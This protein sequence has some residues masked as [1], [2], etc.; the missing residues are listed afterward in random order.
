MNHAALR[1]IKVEGLG[2][3]TDFL[4]TLTDRTKSRALL[5]PESYGLAPKEPIEEGVSRSWD[6]LRKAYA[7]WTEAR[8]E[9]PGT[10][11]VRYWIT[12]LLQELGHTDLQP[13]PALTIGEKTYPI[14]F[15]GTVPVHVTAGEDLDRITLHGS[16]R[17]SPH[18]L[19]QEFLNRSGEHTWGLVLNGERLRLLRDNAQVTRPAFVEFDLEEMFDQ[20]DSAGFRVLWLLT[21]RSRFEGGEGAII[22][23]WNK[24]A[25]AQGTRANDALRDGV[26]RAIATL[27]SGFLRR[28]RDLCAQL[29]TGERQAQDLYRLSL[30][31][32]YQ[33]IFLFVVED[34]DLLH[35]Q[36]TDPVAK[37]RYA[38]YSTRRLR[39]IAEASEG[40]ATHGDAWEGLKVLLRGMY[41]GLPFLGLPAF[42]GHLF[43]QYPLLACGLAN[44]DLYAA[45]RAL[46]LIEDGG[47]LKSVN[48]TDLDAEELG[49]IY[50][51]LLE[52]HPEINTA[53]GT[54]TLSSAAGN[55]R[56][57]TG[58]YYTPT[59][60]I[61][62]LLES[63]LDPVIEDAL[64]K[65]DP[66]AALKALNVV[67]PAC[68]SGHFLLA[69]AR[70]IGLAL[71]RAEHDVTQPSPEQL[72][73]ATREVIAH[74]IYGV[75]L[76]PM[77]IEL[78]KV[79]LWL[80]SAVPGKPLAF[81]DHRLR[82]GNSLLGT[83]PDLMRREDEIP[84]KLVRRVLKPAV[85]AVT[86]HL[87]DE[88]FAELEGDDKTT[89]R[90]LKNRNKQER[91]DLIER[92]HG[93]QGLFD[94]QRDLSGLQRMVEALDRIEPDS[95]EHVQAQESTWSAIQ[96]HAEHRR[97]KT[98]ADA[99]CAAFVTPKTPGAPA[100]TT[101]TLQD[102]DRNPDSLPNVT[103]LVGELAEQYRFFHWHVEFPDV[104]AQGGFDCVLGNP[105]WERIKLQ[106]KEWFAARVPEIAAAPNA[107]ARTRLIAG[108]KTEQ[109]AIYA[110]FVRDLRQAEGESHFI[111]ASGRYP[112]T[113]RG[114]VNTYAIF[115]ELCRQSLNPQGRMG[116]IV[117]TGIATDDTTK[118]FF[119]SLMDKASLA[120][121]YDFEN[122]EGIFPGVHRSFKFCL[123]TVSGEE[124]P[125]AQAQFA[126]FAL[127]AD[128]AR[129][130]GKVFTLSPAEI[131][132]LNPNTRTA[133]VFRSSRDA[134]ITKGIY[135]RVPVLLNEATG[136]NPWGISFMR[137][138]DMSNDSGLF[139][140]AEQLDADGWELHGN[141]YRKGDGQMLP[142]YEAKLMHQFD[143]RFATYTESGDTRDMTSAEKARADALP[144]PRYWVPQTEVEDRLIQKDKNGNVIWEWTRDWL[145]GWRDIARNTDERT[146]I[147]AVYPR[148]AAGDTFLQML[149]DCPVAQIPGL[150]GTLNSFAHDFAVRQKVGGTH[151]KYNVTRQ[152]PVL[153]PSAF[154][155]QRLAFITPRV[156]ELTY[157][158]HDLAGFARD[159]GYDGP[160]FVW[161]DERRFWLRAELDALY[162]HL[163]GIARD[164]VDYI[165]DTF[166]IVRRKDE[167]QYGTYRTKNAIL[168]I[169]DEITRTGV[170]GYRTRLEPKPA[171]ERAAH[172]AQVEAQRS[173]G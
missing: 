58:S 129:D 95:L 116:I 119:Q 12:P 141:R 124:R 134:A 8:S 162:F 72:R 3:S 4:L 128:E 111:R 107:A 169:Y 32:V 49:S 92:A 132:L 166:P 15:L 157:T 104:Y 86:L 165:M 130:P 102:L 67:D 47:T 13:N 136:E 122:R 2:L 152:F 60:L 30:K 150:L 100:I 164:D 11:P 139:R 55:E 73:A 125:N 9:R 78:A 103:A 5:D 23:G 34:R 94:L 66:V 114:D 80:E 106:E 65:P 53:T 33:L 46:S 140:T 64:T 68:G 151:L 88:A 149:P 40:S 98:L 63:S 118:F 115:S 71:A 50:E 51:S 155:P 110:D 85:K 44:S 112:L 48:F 156:L 1:N 127:N 62:L 81:L 171:D 70:R 89:V 120:S 146:F 135:Q 75:D 159:L 83:T 160:P 28:N 163:Y 84:E 87:P 97:L 145:M 7:R 43:E 35:P 79:A 76:N 37:A 137:M 96:E 126:F 56:K 105:P 24:Q 17:A 10:D 161:N 31:L 113:G 172:G 42:G 26:E 38:H 41:G 117:P 74:C 99:W 131:A 153:P 29:A 19:V 142:L 143:H 91:E 121:L 16:L 21:H 101:R 36:D 167:A 45:I 39:Q 18:G 27:G 109:P 168:E 59:G 133:P 20:G 25:S 90:A 148:R 158:A 57:T 22:E 77:A 52:L 93:S 54:F 147:G 123:L 69:A 14:R 154:T 138:F 108:L 170:D 173:W 6:R 61:E 82:S 144:L